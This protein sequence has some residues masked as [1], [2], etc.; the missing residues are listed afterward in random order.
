MLMAPAWVKKHWAAVAVALIVALTTLVVRL[1]GRIWFCK[2]GELLFVI[3]DAYSSHTSQH[4]FDPYSLS[5][6]QHGLAFYWG[7]MWLAPRW[8]WQ[9]RL[10]ASTAIEAAW[11]MI[12]NSAFVINRYREATAALGYTGDSVV[13]VM[14][15]VLS[16]VVGFAVARRLGWRGSLALFTVLEVGMVIAIRDSLLLNILMLFY[17]LE[18]IKQW[19]M[20]A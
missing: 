1:E 17:P 13:N 20:G 15:D 9:A 6:V 3:A 12:E 8:S 19:Q 4:L 11:E 18:A 14:G 16:C 10:V 5:H 2:C 7:L